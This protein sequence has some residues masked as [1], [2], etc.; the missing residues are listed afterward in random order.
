MRSSSPLVLRAVVASLALWLAIPAPAGALEEIP[1]LSQLDSLQQQATGDKNSFGAGLGFRG[2]GEDYFVTLQL[3]L[4]LNLGPVGVGVAFPLNLRVWDRDPTLD[5]LDPPQKDF[6]G[7]L[8]IRREDWDE[9]TEF[10]KIIRYVRLGN[11]GDTF[12]VRAG[13]LTGDI[14]HG[15]IVGRYHNNLDINTLHVGVVLDINTDY[16]GIETLVNDVPTLGMSGVSDTR[17]VAARLYFKPWSLIDPQSILNRFAIGYTI[18]TDLQAPYTMQQDPLSG[19][20]TVVDS[21][22]QVD[23]QRNAV[24]TGLDLEFNVLD[25]PI[26]SLTPYTDFNGIVGAGWGWHAGIYAV[27]KLPIGLDLTMPVRLEYR[28][29]SADY[30]PTYFSTGYDVE[31]FQYMGLAG[32]TKL[33]FV[34][35]QPHGEGLNGLYGDLAFDFVGIFQIGALYE[36]YQGRR[37][38]LAAYLNVP[39]FET[40]QFK[41]YY[42]KT[43][44]AD[45]DDFFTFDER[46]IAIAQIRYELISYVYL[47]GQYMRTWKLDLATGRYETVNDWNI[48]VETGFTF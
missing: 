37:S 39:A 40:L 41:A 33:R 11:K 8:R 3:R 7:M 25:L 12:Y 19:A 1:A 27:A 24:V 16:G 17:L 42:L 22:P 38:Q 4:G 18:A 23:E 10:L 21:K 2:I 5:S 29:F 34:E 44:I 14:G 9:T 43:D 46:S 20:V 13:E 30:I 35:E 48:G 45:V 26:L 31:R 47:V 15:T 28:R 36:G 6:G 32:M